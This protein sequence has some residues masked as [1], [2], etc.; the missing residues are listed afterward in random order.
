M[1]AEGKAK[2]ILARAAHLHVKVKGPADPSD[3][4]SV[5]AHEKRLEELRSDVAMAIL[6][7]DQGK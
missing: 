3:R 6:K 5:E 1:D 2:Q 7:T 4:T